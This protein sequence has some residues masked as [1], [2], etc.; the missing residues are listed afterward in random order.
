MSDSL[1]FDLATR[2]S[3]RLAHLGED[4]CIFTRSGREFGVSVT[5]AREVLTGEPATP[6]PQAPPSLIGV[7]NL[8][9]EV[10]PLVQLDS[11]LDMPTRL[12]STDDQILVVSA[13]DVQIGLVVDRVRDVRSI[14]SGEI[15]AYPDNTAAHHL[16]RGYWASSTGVVTVLDAQRLVAEAVTSVSMRFSQRPPG[17][18]EGARAVGNVSMSNE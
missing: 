6:V 17:A 9:G 1:H 13:G 16:F 12:Y 15:K 18:D 7:I 5:A 11:L 3:A 10:L 8:R 14:D 2:L 4:Y